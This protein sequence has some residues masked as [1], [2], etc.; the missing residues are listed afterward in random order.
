MANIFGNLISGAISGA[1]SAAT[2][3]ASQVLNKKNNTSSGSSGSS[4]STSSKG[5]TSSGSASGVGVYD[6]YQQAIRDQM[7]ANSQAWHNATTQEEKDRLHQA[8]VE[9]AAQLG[10]SVSYDGTTGTWSG[11]S[12]APELPIQQ[13]YQPTDNSAYLEEMAAAYLEKQQEALKQAYEQN[14]SDLAAEQEKLGASYDAAR[15]QEASDNAL[16]RRRWN[17]TAAAYGLNSGTAGQAQLAYSNQLQSGLSALQ[18]AETAANAEIERQ[19]TNLGKE[20]RSAMVQAQAENNYELF[21]KLYEEAVRVDQ[22]LQNQSQFNA[23]Q[24]LKEYQTM[25]DKYYSDLELIYKADE[26]KREDELA[27]AKLAAEAGDYSLYGKYYGWDDERVQ[28]MN[29][30][31]QAS[32][33]P[34]SSGGGSSSGG[35]SSSHGGSSG[36][37]SGSASGS[38]S[39]SSGGSS[40]PVIQAYEAGCKTYS[41]AVAYFK[42]QGYGDGISQELARRLER[43]MAS[44]EL[45]VD[46]EKVQRLYENIVRMWE[47]SEN[48]HDTNF[49]RNAIE[50]YAKQDSLKLNSY[51]K[52]WLYQRFG[53]SS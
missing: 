27:S 43:Q 46:E 23:S 28:Q 31:W 4:G 8:N 29:A 24:A 26:Q 48:R 49:I 39:G 15:S 33:K 6:D 17:E 16:A 38:G 7:N 18:A 1:I 42:A 19:R 44:G 52:A 2:N 22:A 14:L 20:F 11:N 30:L 53:L 9:L 21:Q 25:L 47:T 5:G 50:A 13:D 45:G 12:G 51:E 3:T 36:S 35:S 41:S 32:Q 37:S 34:A 10:G 40:D